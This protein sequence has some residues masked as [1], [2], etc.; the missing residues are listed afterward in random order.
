MIAVADTYDAITSTRVYRAALPEDLAMTEMGKVTG[1]Q[2][3]PEVVDAF[4]DYQGWRALIGDR[5]KDFAGL[6][7]P[8]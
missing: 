1:T 3:D 8:A 6:P 5:A 2:L 4:F 7:N